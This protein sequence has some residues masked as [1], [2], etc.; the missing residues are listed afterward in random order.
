M[1]MGESRAPLV[2]G[3]DGGATSTAAILADAATG[4]ELGRGTDGP[5]NIQAVGEEAALAA[6]EKAVGAAF[7]AAGLSYAPVAAAVL[8]LAGID[9]DG[10]EVIRAWAD[11]VD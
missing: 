11:R 9:L 1:V 10:V 3:I 6:L 2:L 8:G 5:S 4:R 7:E